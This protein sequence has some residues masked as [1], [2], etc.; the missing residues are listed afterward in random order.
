MK[1]KLIKT[2]QGGN[3]PWRLHKISWMRLTEPTTVVDGVNNR[4]DEVKGKLDLINQSVQ[5]LNQTLN[6][7]S[8][9]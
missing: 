5:N 7:S 9:R 4:L 2:K 8:V 1:V 6:W 3:T